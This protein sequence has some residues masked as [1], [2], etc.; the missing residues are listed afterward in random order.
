VLRD[1]SFKTATFSMLT[2]PGRSDLD[3]NKNSD[4]EE[5]ND[6]IEILFR[7]SPCVS[8]RRQSNVETAT[9]RAKNC[10][11]WRRLPE[12]SSRR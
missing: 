7:H 10:R 11:D 8:A 2:N 9:K 4:D 1:F 6:Q 3:E 5:N 12:L